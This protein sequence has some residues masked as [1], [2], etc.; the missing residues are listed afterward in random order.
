MAKPAGICVANHTSPMD[1]QVLSMDN[2][3]AL[4]GQKQGGLLGLIQRALN[5]A[6]DHIWFERAEVNDRLTV[7]QRL[8]EH[9]DKRD[10]MPILIFPEGT[11]INNTSVMMFKKGSFEIEGATVYPVAIKYD[12]RLGDAFWNSSKQSYL[13]YVLM[14][15]TSWA[16]VVDVWYLPA[17]HKQ[18]FSIRNICSIKSRVVFNLQE[19]ESGI[20]FALRVKHVIA[21]A[22]GLVDSSSK[23]LPKFFR[24][25]GQ[26]KRYPVKREEVEK[27]RERWGRR[28][29]RANEKWR[30]GGVDVLAHCP[31]GRPLR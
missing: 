10:A 21:A 1:V 16:T 12:A 15:M 29:N 26:L 9:I 18:T 11:C 19:N 30:L 2:C 7:K 17:M 4:V 31:F 23:L 8:K 22:G 24:R 28:V 25:D 14:L 13:Q 27:Q 20:E 3:Y 6:S 5:R